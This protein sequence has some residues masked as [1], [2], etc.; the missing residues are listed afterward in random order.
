MKTRKNYL[1]FIN[2]LLILSA[3]ALQI[4]TGCAAH[5]AVE[6]LGKGIRRDR[7]TFGGPIIR[8]FGNHIPVPYFAGGTE[9]G[10]N[11]RLNAGAD[12]HLLPLFYQIAGGEAGAT[13][14]PLLQNGYR[15]TIGIGGRLLVLWSFKSKTADSFRIYPIVSVTANWKT[16]LGSLYIGNDLI[17]P[18]NKIDNDPSTPTT[19]YSPFIGHKWEL[20]NGYSLGTELKWQGSNVGSNRVA[21]DYT[22]VQNRGAIATLLSLEKTR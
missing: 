8:A 15:P 13:W 17:L 18:A 21:V 19:L 6:P 5:S 20:G 12:F 9:Y 10:L 16:S 2:S 1:L 7:V 22:G 3:F 14:Y 11:D 4:L